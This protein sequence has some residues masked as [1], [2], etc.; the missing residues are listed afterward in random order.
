MGITS[1]HFRV[2]GIL[3]A[4]L[5]IVAGL[6]GLVAFMLT[7]VQSPPPPGPDPP[8]STNPPPIY[9]GAK[10]VQ[11]QK[12]GFE[13]KYSFGQYLIT[14]ETSDKPDAINAFYKNALAKDGWRQSP[15]EYTEPNKHRFE[16]I[17]GEGG[18][19]YT[20]D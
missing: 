18:P 13:G 8:A 10:Q 11:F 9:P 20:L 12:E 19:Y 14:F 16:W 17:G 15:E 1:R 6:V 3:L 4:C 2:V 7:P 5:V